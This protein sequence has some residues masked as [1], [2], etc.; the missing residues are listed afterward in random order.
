MRKYSLIPLIFLLAVAVLTNHSLSNVT[1]PRNTYL[2]AGVVTLECSLMGGELTIFLKNSNDKEFVLYD[3]EVSPGRVLR[4]GLPQFLRAGDATYLRLEVLGGLS[5]V[6]V[7]LRD[8]ETNV[9]LTLSCV[10]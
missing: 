1:T 8:P 9:S 5:E 7:F 3:V 10:P 6:V 4:A 2:V